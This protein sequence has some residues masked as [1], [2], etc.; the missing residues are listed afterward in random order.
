MKYLVLAATAALLAGPAAAEPVTRSQRVAVADLDLSSAA[1]AARLG[2]RIH[3]SAV[4]LCGTPSQF[5]LVG[6]NRRRGCVADAKARAATNRVTHGRT[7]AEK[8]AS[9]KTRDRAETRLDG[10]KLED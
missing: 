9:T 4:E 3:N 1:G 5:D 6:Q 8:Q 7:K 2:R 10:H